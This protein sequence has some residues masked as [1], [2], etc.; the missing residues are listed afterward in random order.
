MVKDNIL[1]HFIP[2]D[3]SLGSVGERLQVVNILS[4][5]N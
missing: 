3:Y 2:K 5:S 1:F 4:V